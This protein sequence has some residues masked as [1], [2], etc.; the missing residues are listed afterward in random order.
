LHCCFTA[1]DLQN[2]HILA[3]ETVFVGQTSRHFD[4]W[5]TLKS[6]EPDDERNVDNQP[7]R[8]LLKCCGSDLLL[9]KLLPCIKNALHN[10]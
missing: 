8:L 2:G 6:R 4:L 1:D 9:Q 5:V 3:A 7:R 10:K